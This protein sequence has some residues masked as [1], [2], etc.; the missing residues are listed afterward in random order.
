MSRPDFARPS[1][2]LLHIALL[3]LV[4]IVLWA[5]ASEAEPRC[6]TGQVELY[7][8][9][10]VN[11]WTMALMVNMRGEKYSTAWLMGGFDL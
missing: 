8:G 11:I 5:W 10:I 6:S 7:I 9:D 2:L 1:Q 3:H 4:F